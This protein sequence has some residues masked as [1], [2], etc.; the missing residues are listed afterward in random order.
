MAKPRDYLPGGGEDYQPHSGPDT[1]EP[2]DTRPTPQAS[3]PELGDAQALT[4]WGAR[5]CPP[6]QEPAGA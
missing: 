1:L 6:D 3:N 2:G 5:G 4:A